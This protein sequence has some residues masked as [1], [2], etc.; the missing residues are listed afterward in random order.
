MFLQLADGGER[1]RHIR[2]PARVQRNDIVLRSAPVVRPPGTDAGRHQQRQQ[3]RRRGPVRGVETAGAACANLFEPP[4]ERS[5]IGREQ[6]FEVRI[7]AVGEKHVLP[8]LKRI[9]RAVAEGGFARNQRLPA[10]VVRKIARLFFGIA[11]LHE[12]G[13]DDL[14]IVDRDDSSAAALKLGDPAQQRRRTLP[15]Q[16]DAERKIA[17]VKL[18][19]DVENQ[20]GD[21]VADFAPVAARSGQDLAGFS[22]VEPPGFEIGVEKGPEQF[23]NPP[24]TGPVPGEALKGPEQPERLDRFEKIARRALRHL[25]ERGG[26]PRKKR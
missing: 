20:H 13:D 23:V 18:F 11:E 15:R 10:A 1:V 17:D 7:I 25:R 5:G 22:E 19:D 9:E 4:P 26:D 14:F 8:D 16:P 2:Q 6:R 24:E 21:P 12:G 3:R